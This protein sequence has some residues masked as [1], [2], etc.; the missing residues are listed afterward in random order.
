MKRKP[1][2]KVMETFIKFYN[3]DEGATKKRV[4]RFSDRELKGEVSRYTL[5]FDKT[6]DGR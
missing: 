4:L 6:G 2:W 1:S 3:K 5:S